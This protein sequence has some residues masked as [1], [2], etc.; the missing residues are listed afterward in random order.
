MRSSVFSEGILVFLTGQE[1]IES[2]ANNV[3]LIAKDPTMTGPRMDCFTLFAS[4][5]GR[6]KN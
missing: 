6:V 5:V 1:E 4:Q 2:M 3:K